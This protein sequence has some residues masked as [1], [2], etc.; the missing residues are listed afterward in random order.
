MLSW[1]VFIGGCAVVFGTAVAL[2]PSPETEGKSPA[3]PIPARPHI[4]ALPATPPVPNQRPAHYVRSDLNDGLRTT[5]V[6]RA[7]EPPG[8]DDATRRQLARSIADIENLRTVTVYFFAAHDAVDDWNGNAELKPSD[9]RRLRGTVK[10]DGNQTVSLPLEP[11]VTPTPLPQVVPEPATVETPTVDPKDEQRA[12]DKLRLA[13]KMRGEGNTKT[14]DRWLRDL[15]R[16]YPMTSAARE[17]KSIL[18]ID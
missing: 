10:V 15:I 16:E 9:A 1:I 18:G 17:A 6:V 11:E 5:H 3:P 8:V 14:G 7:I 13:K 4:P 12:A 2:A